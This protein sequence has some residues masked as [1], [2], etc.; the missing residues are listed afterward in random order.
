M[1]Y[2]IPGRVAQI[3]TYGKDGCVAFTQLGVRQDLAQDLPEEEA[4]VVYTDP[5]HD[6]MIRHVIVLE[7]G[8]VIFQIYNGY[9]FFG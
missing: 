2:S 4:D 7:P 8:L 1:E 6:P 3:K 5:E 9:W